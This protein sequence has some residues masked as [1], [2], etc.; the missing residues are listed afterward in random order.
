MSVASS[1]NEK[2]KK[3]WNVFIIVIILQ[4]QT[5][6]AARDIKFT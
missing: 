4:C 6:G 3:T 5:D 2:Y 1:L